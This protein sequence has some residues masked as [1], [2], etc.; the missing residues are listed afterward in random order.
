[1]AGETVQ[2][3]EDIQ[4]TERCQGVLNSLKEITLLEAANLCKAIEKEF[5]VTA[6]AG[7]P[8]GLMMPG[9]GGA[10]EGDKAEEKTSF[11]IVLKSFGMQ[12]IPVI[13]LVRSVTSLGLKEAKDLVESAPKAIKEGVPKEEAEELKKKFEEVGAEMEIR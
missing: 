3:S 1:M 7:I 2:E 12:K 4:L 9:A 11:D 10:A 13:K 8:A 5:G 6:A